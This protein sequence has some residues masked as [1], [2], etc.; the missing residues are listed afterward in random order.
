MLIYNSHRKFPTA[1]LLL[2]LFYIFS[3]YIIKNIKRFPVYNS[4]NTHGDWFSPHILVISWLTSEMGYRIG[5]FCPIMLHC[6]VHFPYFAHVN[7]KL[8]HGGWV[9]LREFHIF[10]LSDIKFPTLR[11]M[12]TVK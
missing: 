3:A 8:Q 7:G 12:I 1:L 11:V 5:L 2:K 6:D 10:H 4:V 9:T